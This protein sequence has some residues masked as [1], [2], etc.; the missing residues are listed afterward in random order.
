MNLKKLLIAFIFFALLNV[1]LVIGASSQLDAQHPV[2]VKPYIKRNG[3][4]VHQYWRA[5]RYRSKIFKK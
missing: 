1:A 3:H 2:Q 4:Y 5:P